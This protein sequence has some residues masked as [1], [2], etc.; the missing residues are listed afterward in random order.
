MTN[1]SVQSATAYKTCP[2][3][4][5]SNLQKTESRE[6]TC[7]HK[8]KAC[9]KVGFKSTNNGRYSRDATSLIFIVPKQ[10]RQDVLKVTLIK[11]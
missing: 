11:T 6:H 7:N 3:N 2:T 10:T 8:E 9:S 5:K 4:L 1:P